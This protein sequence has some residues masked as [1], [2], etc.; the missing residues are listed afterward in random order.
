[1]QV[2]AVE[3]LG[4]AWAVRVEGLEPQVYASGA[5]AEDA[6]KTVATRLAATGE[7]VE[8]H[9]L[10]RDGRKGARFVCL[11]PISEEDRPL[12]VGGPTINHLNVH[13]EL[14]EA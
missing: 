9:V 5:K 10:L 14:I 12:L 7:H 13:D 2:I 6:A 4:D 8:L 3:P 1:M 11:P